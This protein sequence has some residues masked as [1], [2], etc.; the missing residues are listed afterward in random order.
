MELYT[1]YFEILIANNQSTWYAFR[2]FEFKN[3]IQLQK[4]IKLI[5]KI[6][7][8]IHSFINISI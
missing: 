4:V 3:Y 7:F 8:V 6:I 5:L 1:S 2:N